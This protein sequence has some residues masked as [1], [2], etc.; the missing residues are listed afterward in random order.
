MAWFGGPTT[1]PVGRPGI[2]AVPQ[3]KGGLVHRPT[4]RPQHRVRRA[5]PPAQ[6]KGAACCSRVPRFRSPSRMHSPA[7]RPSCPGT[8]SLP[9]PDRLRLRL[10]RLQPPDSDDFLAQVRRGC[11]PARPTD[12]ATA[13]FAS[14]RR[15]YLYGIRAPDNRP[16]GSVFGHGCAGRARTPESGQPVGRYRLRRAGPERPATRRSRTSIQ[17]IR[18]CSISSGRIRPA[19]TPPSAGCSATSRPASPRRESATRTAGRPRAI[20]ISSLTRYSAGFRA[21]LGRAR[22]TAAARRD[23]RGL[24]TR[25]PTIRQHRGWRMRLQSRA[26]PHPAGA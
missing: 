7:Q 8:G 15:D 19:S 4:W 1:Q 10:P 17:P 26:E 6:G 24:P 16:G 25:T 18:R 12:R 2:P 21:A 13:G 23:C 11:D 5:F 9:G 14:A 3:D 20:R 22:A